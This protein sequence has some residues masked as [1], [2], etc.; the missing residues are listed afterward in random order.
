M[1]DD[2]S[3]LTSADFI[4][5]AVCSILIISEI[6]FIMIRVNRRLSLSFFIVLSLYILPS[7]L[8]LLK[9]TLMKNTST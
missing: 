5:N 3:F 1:A 2:S 6:S 7:V 4:V 8:R 9:Y